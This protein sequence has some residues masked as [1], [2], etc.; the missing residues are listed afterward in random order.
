MK[1][2]ESLDWL[3]G[4][5][6]LAIMIYHFMAWEFVQPQSGSLLGNF[7]VYGVSIFFVLS[8]LSMAIVY[9]NYIRDFDSSLVFFIR[10][11]FRLLP[12]LW[13][14]ISIT[15][16]IN[17][18]LNG[19]IDIYKIFLN[20]T[21]LFGFIAP[22]EYIN[23]GAWSIGNEV[24]YYAFTPI[25]IML[26][27]RN[28]QAANIV[29]LSLVALGGYFAFYALDP[30]KTLADQWQIYIN[31]FNNFFLYA[32]GLALYYNLH[33][34]NMA[35]IAPYLILASMVILIFYPVSGNQINIVTGIN[36]CIFSIAA[37]VLTL[38]FYKLEVNFPEWFSKP[39]ANLGESTYGVY[40]LHPILL[41]FVNKVISN[42]FVSVALTGVITII[43]ANIS[44][45]FYERPFIKIGKKQRII[46]C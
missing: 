45:K 12:L 29:V 14:T 4:L 7:G 18:I 32:C 39:F 36:R 35:K 46:L 34:L 8:G 30:S 16:G 20:V 19:E 43:V 15:T 13:V 38:G 33:Q 9:N 23:T 42:P 1:R 11:L 44:Y 5:M 10:R 6:A 21:L 41:M 3:R 37:I 17:F 22:G 27:A 40:I 26:Y 24:F 2:Y 25:L 31:P 28:K